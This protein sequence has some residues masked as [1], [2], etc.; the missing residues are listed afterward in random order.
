ME[1]QG[2]RKDIQR[3]HVGGRKMR[4]RN[5]LT[6]WVLLTMGFIHGIAFPQPRYGGTLRII[7]GMLARVMHPAEMAPSDSIMTLPATG[8]GLCRWGMPGREDA[9]VPDMAE[10]WQFDPNKKVLV[11]RLR[12][13]ITFQDGAP[14]NAEAVKWNYMV[15]IEAGRLLEGK[16][17]IRIET[18]D[19]HTVVL[20]LK[21]VINPLVLLENYGHVQQVSP[22]SVKQHGDEW[23]R[24]NIVGAGPFKLV[25][26]KRD[27][28]M[29]FVRYENYW[30]KGMPYLDAIEARLILDPMTARAML[31]A[32]QADMWHNTSDIEQIAALEQKGFKVNYGPGFLW[33]LLPD[34]NNP[35]S[36]FAD[37]RVREALEYALDRPAIA[38]MVGRGRYEPLTQL[39]P[40]SSPAYVKGFDRRPYNPKK[41]KEL[42]A[43]AGYPNGFRTTLLVRQ[44]VQ[45]LGA[46]IQAYLSRVGIHAEIDLADPGR[47]NAALF[48]TGWKGLALG[49]SGINPVPQDLFIHFGPRPLTYRTNTFAKSQEFLDL[50]EK[51]YRSVDY[52]EFIRLVK[53]AIKQ[54]SEDA[55]VIPV[56]RAPYACVM[57]PSVQSDWPLIHMIIWTPE[58]DWIAP[59]P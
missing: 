42:L 44:G 50:C 38:N 43:Q 16:N 54:A 17:I 23:A 31:E 41:A 2:H 53:E 8:R 20:F 56:V 39:V 36:P 22:A 57:H 5:T 48:G 12:K 51:A 35:G 24:R 47:Y 14:F 6:F 18:P 55:M 13:G 37:K 27:D 11:W 4:I 19:E 33:A 52:N 10:S 1:R 9:Y 45:E 29:K 26:F 40:S 28:Y 58:D 3:H 49:G 46:A 15:R 25:E 34:S 7:G 21:D 59:R 30:R 32:G